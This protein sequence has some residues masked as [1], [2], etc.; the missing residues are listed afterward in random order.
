MQGPLVLGPPWIAPAAPAIVTAL[1]VR[2]LFFLFYIIEK[3][4]YQLR[5]CCA[6]VYW[7]FIAVVIN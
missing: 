2:N 6:Q 1:V 5:N 4:M 3:F 7:K